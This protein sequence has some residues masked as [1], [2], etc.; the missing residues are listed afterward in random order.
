VAAV[1]EAAAAAEATS[2]IGIDPKF[3]WKKS[4]FVSENLKMNEI[5]RI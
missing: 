5:P 1:A 3:G 2:P 4:F